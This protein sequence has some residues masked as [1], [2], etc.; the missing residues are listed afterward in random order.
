MHYNFDERIDRR[1]TLSLKYDFTKERGKPDGLIPLWVADMDFRTPPEVVEALVAQSRHGIFGYSDTKIDYTETVARWFASRFD[2]QPDPT[3]L[4]KTPG[5]VFAI[6]TAIRAFTQPGEAVLVQRP[7]YY[8]FFQQVQAN[9]RILVN[10]PLVYE[11]GRYR[12]DFDDFEAKIIASKVRLFLLC[13]PHNPV[14][15]VW[16]PEELCRLNDICLR[17]GV[18]VISDEI[19]ADFIFPG[20]RHHIVASLNPA[21]RDNS[22]ICTAPSKTFNLAGLQTSNIFIANAALRQSFQEEMRRG[23]YSQLN[24]MGLIACQAAY[25]HGAP[26]LT[27]LLQYLQGNLDFVRGFLRR[28]LPQ[29]RLVEPEGTYLLWLDFTGLFASEADRQ[30]FLLNEAR[31]W[32][33]NGSMFGPEG[34]PF[35]RLNMACPRATLEQAF[36]QLKEGFERHG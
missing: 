34:S 14:G 16:T 33:D 20:H 21:Y 32:L 18:I 30:D 19:H 4:V 28:H 24:T 23:G 10:N 26:W 8:P 27:E 13:S 1:N 6:A 35:E 11:D 2:W 17:H 25:T 36:R 7:V 12:I 22:V 29:I 15:R 3:W 9:Q 31:L 5:I